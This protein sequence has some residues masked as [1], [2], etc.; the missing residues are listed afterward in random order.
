MAF[1]GE[2]FDRVMS[3]VKNYEAAERRRVE[4]YA[5]KIQMKREHLVGLTRSCI[6]F[7]SN[8][9]IV[10]IC[11][12]RGEK[13]SDLEAQ[14]SVK[15]ANLAW[16]MENLRGEYLLLPTMFFILYTVVFYVLLMSIL[17]R[18]VA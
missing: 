4:E 2:E 1:V 18:M 8:S 17:L 6:D 7:L 12:K 11:S 3:G 13:K 10:E 9:N 14:C 15:A 5:T 16:S